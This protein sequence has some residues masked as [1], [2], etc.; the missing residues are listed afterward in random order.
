MKK[1]FM[2]IASLLIAAMLLVVS[3]APEANVEGKVEDTG[4]VNA[5]LMA[6]AAGKALTVSSPEGEALTYTITLEAKWDPNS[7]YKMD[8]VVGE[9]TFNRSSISNTIEL[10]WI[11]Q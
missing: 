10:G 3:C 5:S 2:A 7:E 11:S 4:L 9:K 6:T 1:N 8:E